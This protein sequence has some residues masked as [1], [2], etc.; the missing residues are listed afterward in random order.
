[1]GF[2]MCIIKP[3]SSLQSMHVATWLLLWMLTH[4]SCNLRKTCANA[5]PDM[6]R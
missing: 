6:S 2:F 1:M 5:R 4:N 3:S